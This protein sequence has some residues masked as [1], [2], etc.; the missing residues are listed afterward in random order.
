MSI[1]SVQEKKHKQTKKPTSFNDWCDF[2]FLTIDS[3]YQITTILPVYMFVVILMYTWCVLT[4]EYQG[5]PFT[6]QAEFLQHLSQWRG[7]QPAR[8]S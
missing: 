1:L 7:E 2:L 6:I 3:N 8:S 4:S 5:Y